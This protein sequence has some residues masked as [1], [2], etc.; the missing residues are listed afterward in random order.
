MGYKVDPT[1]YQAVLTQTEFKAAPYVIVASG[2]VVVV[3]A[4]LGMFGACCGAL[5]NKILLGT[6]RT[7]RYCVVGSD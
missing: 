3:I 1:D 5:C 2:C 4:A 7:Q 6:V